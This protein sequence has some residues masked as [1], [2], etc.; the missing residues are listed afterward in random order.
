MAVND[1]HISF[2]VVVSLFCS[3][4]ECAQLWSTTLSVNHRH[5]NGGGG[6]DVVGC[7]TYIIVTIHRPDYESICE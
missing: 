1:L 2:T 7:P 6:V 5:K 4:P 3:V